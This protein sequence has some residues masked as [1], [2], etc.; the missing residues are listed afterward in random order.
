MTSRDDVT[1]R[2]SR[3]APLRRR[4]RAVRFPRLSLPHAPAVPL[5]AG[6]A[7]PVRGQA[8][9]PSCYCRCGR[10]LAWGCCADCGAA[11]ASAREEAVRPLQGPA[12]R[13][14]G[15]ARSGG[16]RPRPRGERGGGGGARGGSATPGWG[17]ADG[18]AGAAAR[19]SGSGGAERFVSRCRA[20]ASPPR[21]DPR[22]ARR[23]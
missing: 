13:R 8:P 14:P 7:F 10:R 22:S 4:T 20:G 3:S 6:G 23:R 12:G 17:T 19:G 21:A 1:P 15:A 16:R 11:S 9:P 5:P 18:G 2:L